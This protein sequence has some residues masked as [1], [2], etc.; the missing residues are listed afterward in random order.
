M[1]FIGQDVVLDMCVSLITQ[2]IVC[3]CMQPRVSVLFIPSQHM[4]T[5]VLP[6]HTHK[7]LMNMHTHGLCHILT[8]SLHRL[9]PIYDQQL[10]LAYTVGYIVTSHWLL[11]IG[12]WAVHSHTWTSKQHSFSINSFQVTG[13]L[14][15]LNASLCFCILTCCIPNES[16]M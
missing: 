16:D 13:F 14:I 7:H 8:L 15:L 10:C 6:K 9:W 2:S 1:F 12:Y 3:N 4:H 11:Y 5:Y